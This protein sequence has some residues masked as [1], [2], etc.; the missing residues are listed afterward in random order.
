METAH[1]T[2]PKK[3]IDA[4]H[5]FMKIAEVVKE[6]STCLRD[7]VGA[8]LVRDKHIISTGYNGAPSGLPHCTDIGYCIRERLG[9]PS[10]ERH[11][12]SRGVHA[13]QNAIIQAALH[14]VSTEN[15]TLYC[16]H[17]PCS[18][19]AKMLI[20]AKVKRVVYK[21]HYPDKMAFDYFKQAGVEVVHL[22]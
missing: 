11:E 12:L 21:R 17:S 6:R 14:G 8:V 5:Y 13:E 15:S 22:D 9:V 19:C 16:T 7:Q 3:R 20:N 10:G 18:V 2:K 1:E 4:D